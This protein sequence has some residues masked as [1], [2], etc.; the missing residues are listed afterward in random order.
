MRLGGEVKLRAF[1]FRKVEI[2]ATDR[3]QRRGLNA[4]HI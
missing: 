3:E 1:V 2:D 4:T